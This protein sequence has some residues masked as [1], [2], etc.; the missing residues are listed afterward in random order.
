MHMVWLNSL[1]S[2]YYPRIRLGLG[3]AIDYALKVGIQAIQDRVSY[4]ASAI[5]SALNEI[6]GVR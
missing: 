5:R 6:D 3:V 1:I 2:S 4:L